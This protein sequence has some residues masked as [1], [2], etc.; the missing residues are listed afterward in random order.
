MTPFRLAR[1][2]LL[3]RR[4]TRT[5]HSGDKEELY[6]LSDTGVN[7]F[8]GILE[9]VPAHLP[10]HGPSALIPPGIFSM[11]A[12]NYRNGIGRVTPDESP[13]WTVPLIDGGVARRWTQHHVALSAVFV[14]EPKLDEIV[15]E[16]NA[17]VRG[18]R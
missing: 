18:L 15:A 12:P 9:H 6:P 2:H 5:P 17:S 14:H 10:T 16:T 4:L 8:G 1:L 11:L 3:W 13:N 7:R